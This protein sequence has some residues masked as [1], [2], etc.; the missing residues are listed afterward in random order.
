MRSDYLAQTL[1]LLEQAL[2]MCKQEHAKHLARIERELK[3]LRD[4]EI[5]DKLFLAFVSMMR[6]SGSRYDL[7]ILGSDEWVDFWETGKE[8]LPNPGQRHAYLMILFDE[9]KSWQVEG[10]QCVPRFLESAIET[11]KLN[12]DGE[13]IPYN[14]GDYPFDEKKE[15]VGDILVTVF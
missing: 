15:N 4:V 14:Y 6:R 12:R 10:E 9:M 3:K 7:P 2:A 1:T 8:E 13:L 5:S 11:V